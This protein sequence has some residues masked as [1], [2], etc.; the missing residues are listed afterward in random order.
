MENAI[1][2]AFDN[3]TNKNR[4]LII[5]LISII[6]RD[7][8]VSSINNIILRNLIDLSN[9]AGNNNLFHFW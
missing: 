1:A 2:F 9:Y 6:I 5:L 8:S 4:F 7:I 3:A